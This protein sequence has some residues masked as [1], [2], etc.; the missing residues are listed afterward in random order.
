MKVLHTFGTSSSRFGLLLQWQFVA[1][2]EI[3][4][5]E[6]LHGKRL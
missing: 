6:I 5:E 4:K 2:S 1:S 3:L